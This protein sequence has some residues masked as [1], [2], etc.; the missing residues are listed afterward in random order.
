MNV[1]EHWGVV[2]RQ[3]RQSWDLT[4]EDVARMLG[5]SQASVTAWERGTRS[6]DPETLAKLVKALDIDPRVLFTIDVEIR[7]VA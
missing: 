3:H 2:I 1:R 4:Q 7:D 6:P 5:V